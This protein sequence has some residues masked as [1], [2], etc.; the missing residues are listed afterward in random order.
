MFSL[1]RFLWLIGFSSERVRL[2]GLL[3]GLA[4]AGHSITALY[5]G[6]MSLATRT[7]RPIM[8]A[9]MVNA[10]GQAASAFAPD[11][12]VTLSGIQMHPAI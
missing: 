3:K 2:S 6:S 1:F 11:E 7:S 9:A 8:V 10:T 12:L 4:I 5:P